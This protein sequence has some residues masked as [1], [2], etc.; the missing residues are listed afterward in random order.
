[1][2]INFKLSLALILSMLIC[3]QTASSQGFNSI[4][5]PDGVYVIAVGDAGLMF[6]SQNGGSSWASYT[7][8]SVDLKSV[9]TIN[10][11]V[12]IAGSNGKIYK[13]LKSASPVNEINIGITTSLNSVSFVSENVGY[14]C[15]NS[16]V[17]YKT[18]NG[19]TNWTAANTGIPPT[20]DLTSISFIDANKGIAGGKEGKVYVTNDGGVQWTA[21]NTGATRNIKDVKYFTDG[22][23][24]AG[25]HGTLIYKVGTGDWTSV[26]TRIITDINSITGTGITDVHVCGGGGFIRNNRN[27]NERF[28]NFEVNPMLG[29]LVDV[30]YFDGLTGFAVSS[31]NNAIIRTTNGGAQWTLTAGA[32]VS[33]QW[34]NKLSAS[35]GI[36][37]NLC[38]HPTDPNTVF[39]GYGNRVYVS[40]NRGES[41]TQIAAATG[42]GNNMH[43][44]YVSPLDTNV[45]VA[46]ITGSPD[47]VIKTT[48]YGVNWSISYQQNFSNYG[49]PLEMDQNDPSIFYFAPDGGGF[50]KSTDN[51]STFTEISGNYPF[52]SPCDILVMWDSSEVIFVG[53]GVTGSGQAVIFKSTNG[54]INWTNI[55]TV[56]SSETPSMTNSVFDQSLI[57]A[58]EWSGSNIYKSVDYGSSFTISHSTGFSGWASSFCLEDPTLITTGNYGSN[59][60]ISLNKGE[61]WVYQGGLSGAGAGMLNPDRGMILTMQTSSLWKLKATYSVLTNVN[62]T[63]LS[64]EPGSYE[65]SQN[66][67][68]PFNPSTTI[69][70]TLPSAANVSLK[71]FDQLGRLVNVL[72]EGYRNA[73]SYEVDF[74]A[75]NFTSGVYFYR[76]TSDGGVDITKK[77]LLVK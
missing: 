10:N 39:C 38:A 62:E 42:F 16:G 8:P 22:M 71:V 36:G 40:R 29:N 72:S 3:T 43:S 32:T 75:S 6:R 15:G 67:P 20:L 57:I 66:Y 54:G 51:G 49:Q 23:A 56:A 73:G 31:L 13:T 7:I 33:Y 64:N 65:L 14:V 44:F 24:V 9:S 50:Y 4:S 11:D 47:R 76:L 74:N 55:R 37:N 63:Q 19:G 2:I 30:H 25:E 1:M 46:A 41:W 45:W 61:S 12:W 60:A 34:Q 18:V 26:N 48:N 53:D 5:S 68:N 27:N 70:F 17:I 77:M 69:K 21:E 58:T 35:G 52:R 59:S 28:Y